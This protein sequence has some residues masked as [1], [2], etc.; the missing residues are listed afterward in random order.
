MKHGFA[1]ALTLGVTLTCMSCATTHTQHRAPIAL[2]DFE[3]ND[4]AGWT[5]DANWRIDN[6]TA[7][8][9]YSGWQGNGFAWSGEGGEPKVGKLRSE[10]FRLERDGVEVL[11][12]GW[13]DH[14]G[15][16]ADRWNYVTLNLADGR[17]LDRAY[18]PNTT[19]FTP[20][21]LSGGSHEGAMVYVETVDD[22]YEASYS[23]I[24][25]D[26]V[27]QRDA[28]A[29]PALPA[30]KPPR[31]GH[32]LENA[33]YRVEVSRRNGA[34][35]RIRDKQGDIEFIRE[36]RLAG[37]Y[38][39]TL[40][41]PGDAA[42]QATE[43]N[44]IVGEDQ[45]LASVER[46]DNRLTLTWGPG[47]ESVIGE[48]Y[49]VVVI[50]KIALV[51]DWIEFGLDIDNR[52]DLEIGELFYPLLGGTMG[53]AP[54]DPRG[55]V[56]PRK[57]EL[58]LPVGA[59]VQSARIFHTFENHSW[60]GILGP[61][62]HYG[63]PTTLSMPWL[64]LSHAGV[65]R[66]MYF[67]AHDPVYR[68]KVMHLEM[69]PGVAGNRSDGNWPR[70]D[71]L[72]G[73]PEGVRIGVV[74]M[75][76][77]PPRSV[78]TASPVVLR[79]HDGGWEE[80]ARF[81]AEQMQLSLASSTAPKYLQCDAQP[82][83][84]LPECAADAIV[85]GRDTLLLTHWRGH[86]DGTPLFDVAGGDSGGAS[87]R[88]AISRCHDAGVKVMFS[89]D[90]EPAA[91]DTKDYADTLAEFACTDRWGILNTV[92]VGGSGDRH[93]QY[94][95]S[96]TRRAVLN[97][98]A[99]GYRA[100][101]VKCAANLALLGADGIHIGGF[102]SR[103]LDFNASLETTADCA[104]WEG[105]LQTIDAMLLEGRKVNPAFTLTTDAVT[106]RILT[107]TGVAG[108]TRPEQSPLALAFPHWTPIDKTMAKQP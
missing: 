80:A 9:W 37:N 26:S 56:D 75:P 10:P 54:S 47:L 19:K 98:A 28:V 77:Q 107:R 42:W 61:E 89:I 84:R 17:E 57:T 82:F 103:A 83:D 96:T 101:L 53:V 7:G 79:A 71:E 45:R 106:D 46:S 92:V 93:S 88:E 12:A 4:L 69:F 39:F 33:L 27:T 15:Q 78:Y 73:L 44:Y 100:H 6:N 40:P 66:G 91:M 86:N 13:A 65:G 58:L 16:T 49:D 18:A 35:T 90:I 70:T 68:Y 22:G 102:F 50:M 31:E 74:H 105:A 85:Q 21:F 59:G 94:I 95:A 43:A 51:E 99:P 5:A 108:S 32:V 24:C 41:I 34:I 48:K 2:W 63:Y 104:S 67:G 29:M 72:H 87:L 38:K 25:I 55:N 36:P 8:G 52:T 20:V 97:P 11:L 60:L 62:Q 76:Y 64:D 81:Y 30:Y 3:S 14:G 1:T 23:M